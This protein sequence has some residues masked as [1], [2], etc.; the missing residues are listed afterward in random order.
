MENS[1]IENNNDLSSLFTNLKFEFNHFEVEINDEN[2]FL[3]YIN[4]INNIAINFE[5]KYHYK[6]LNYQNIDEKNEKKFL[7]LFSKKNGINESLNS[8]IKNTT[9]NN[10]ANSN[11][12][13]LN[14][15]LENNGQFCYEIKLGHGSWENLNASESKVNLKIG[16]LELNKEN[17]KELN[18][19]IT[20]NNNKQLI[21]QENNN[22]LERVNLFAVEKDN[23]GNKRFEEY[24]KSIYY[25]IN[26][27]K[28]KVPISNNLENNEEKYRLIQKNDIIGIVYNNKSFKDFIE[29]NVYINGK[30]FNSELITK[31][32]IDS[33]NDECDDDFELEKKRKNS[34]ISRVLVPFIEVGDN[35]TI[36]IKDKSTKKKE[37]RNK[38]TF[39]ERIEYID[40]YNSPPLNTLPEEIIELQNITK[41]Y[42]DILIKVGSKIFKY[43]K[44]EIN[45][46]FKQLISFFKNFSFINRLVAENCLMDFLM[47]GI[48]MNTGNI[49]KFK[50]N[51]ETLLNVIDEIEK[52]DASRKIKLLEK[53][54]CYIIEAIMENST[55]FLDVYKLEESNQNE[56]ENFTKSKF[57]L[58]FLLFENYFN[59]DNH[60][61][62]NLLSQ[63]SLFKSENNIQSILNAIIGSCFYFNPINTEE[64]IKKY[65]SNNRFQKIQFLDAN[66]RAYINDKIYNK[67]FEDNRYMMKIIIKEIDI[68]K[69]EKTLYLIKFI[70]S[71]CFTDD[72]VSIINFII[73]NLIRNYF[74][75]SMNIDKSKVEKIIF[76]NYIALNRFVSNE[77]ENTFYGKK[78]NI[79]NLSTFTVITEEER[80]EALIFNL[81]IKCVSNYYE[82]FS[83]KEKS[84]NEIL[85]FLSNPTNNYSDIELY[86]INHMVEFY[87]SIYFGNFYLHL[88]YF[89]NYLLKF[90]LICI[91]EK[92]LEVVPYNSILQ[93]ILFILDML[94][95]RSCFIEKDNLIEKNEIGM[96]CS[97]VDKILKYVTTFLGEVTPRI[98][99]NNFAPIEN[100]EEMI[101]LH[102]K[103]L[104]KVLGFDKN[105]IKDCFNSIQANLVLTFKNLAELYDKDK[106]KI[107]YPNINKLIEFLYESESDKSQQIQLATRNIFFKNIMEK[108]LEEFKKKANDDNLAKSN[109]IEHTM[110]Y[111]IFII[112]YKRTKIIRESL[113][114]I[115]ENNFLFENNI[116]YQ[117][118]YL[119][120]FTKIIK[121]FYNFLIDNNMNMIFDTSTSC[122]LKINSFVCKTFKTLHDENSLKK[123]QNIYEEN[124]KIFE[125]FFTSFF[126]LLSHLLIMKDQNGRE[127]YY[128]M[129]QNRKGFYF[130]EFKINFEKLFGYPE[131]KTM[132]EFL[133]IL[134]NKFRQLCDDK[135][136]LNL[137]DVNDNSIEL[138]KR[139]S[140]PICLDFTDENDVHINPC[141]HVIHKHC[142]EEL[143]KKSNKNQCPLC[144]RNI[145]GIK[146]DPSFTVESVNS[147]QSSSSLF[148]S[149]D[150]NPFRR[151]NIFLFGSNSRND[152]QR[153]NES[154][155][156]ENFGLFGAPNRGLFSND[157]N[158]NIN[159]NVGGGLFGN[160][161]NSLFG[162]NSNSL[163][164]NSQNNRN[165]LFGGNSL[166]G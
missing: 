70:E 121:I 156:R 15:I 41:G 71:F 96:F 105:I 80:K 131:C 126:F 16:L 31:P 11:V 107:L 46:Y 111:N 77:E 123:I 109:Y 140:C 83:K 72:N 65:Y 129:A 56:F 89:T 79:T 49:M 165:N 94:K 59:Q 158:M 34:K 100:F 120:K 118:E 122:F 76:S 12:F 134:L 39:N 8:N 40:I 10:Y 145:L 159:S 95:I 66:F 18:E 112:I 149:Q 124:N 20:L 116:F 110:Y 68:N 154:N 4:K 43:K 91:K 133:D 157:N 22:A 160:N 17:L 27:D 64:Y 28:F 97:I 60:I 88:Y 61:S 36:F 125:D 92:Y 150:R 50:E 78:D 25:G 32:K 137:E 161:S 144:K 51:V 44:N 119:S 55:N 33:E 101:S 143:I 57:V 103:I 93:N 155:Q 139:D 151:P 130:E 147:S 23:D 26:I 52:N 69:K 45:T 54:I 67:I 146:E 164:G 138:D 142:L 153:S 135:D 9:K 85:E 81:I 90:L 63:V 14:N 113:S 108:E 38:I 62:Y 37:L 102:I 1:G 84:A 47:S 99:N 148:S 7:S 24:K 127:Y 152:S 128:Q 73:L 29:I 166:F 21:F 6:Y 86:K 42:F 104:I 132:I 53:I 30:L 3:N 5:K 163:F 13:I 48:D 2:S 74:S 136:V 117:R 19:L 75:K 35:K 115:F 162:N 106:Y 82:V 87:Q 98:R 114:K 141:N 58:C